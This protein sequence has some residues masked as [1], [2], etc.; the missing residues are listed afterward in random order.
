MTGERGS[1]GRS[2]VAAPPTAETTYGLFRRARAGDERALE[3]LCER[4]LPRMKRWARGRLPRAARS[5]EDTDDLV[6]EVFLRTLHRLGRFEYRQEHALQAYLHRAIDN[7]I[8]NGLRHSRRRPAHRELSDDIA[9]QQSSTLEELAG[10][11]TVR[12]YE[13]A[14][15]RLRPA[16]RDAIMAKLE[17]DCSLEE[18]AAALGKPS[19][20]AARKAVARAILRLAREMASDV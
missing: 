11:E 5:V 2:G 18:L 13:A 3:Q 8:H 17:L 1:V 7:R 9:S 4:F 12:R 16:D 19:P 20:D 14:L 15:S 10:R 6:Q